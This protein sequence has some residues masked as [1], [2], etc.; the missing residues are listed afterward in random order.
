M[1]DDIYNEDADRLNKQLYKEQL[2]KQLFNGKKYKT[3]FSTEEGEFVL[4]D[5][6]NYFDYEQI[7]IAGS[8]QSFQDV[9]FAEGQRFVINYIKSQI[10]NADIILHEENDE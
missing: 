7:F 8:G 1:N 2:Q 5:L 10:K 3:C 4:D 6:I 9:A